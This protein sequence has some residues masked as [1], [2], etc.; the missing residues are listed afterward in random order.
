MSTNQTVTRS[1]DLQEFRRLELCDPAN[2]VDLVIESGETENLT[3]T[4]PAKIVSR[5]KTRVK[6][7]IL[8]ISLDGNFL[9]K[10]RDSLTTSLTRKR[11]AY[12]LTVRQLDEIDLCGLIRVDT[13][14][15]E[16]RKPTIRRIGP[17]FFPMRISSD[18]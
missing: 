4:G 8:T 11:I 12:H 15:L 16:I 10:I 2:W 5:I 7:N 13:C 18:I 1:R 6:N 14:G 3:I 17:W 9:D